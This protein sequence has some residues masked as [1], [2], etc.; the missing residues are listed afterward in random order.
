MA[1]ITKKAQRTISGSL[2]RFYTV[3]NLKAV[4][5]LEDLKVSNLLV[6]ELRLKDNRILIMSDV[7]LDHF[8]RIVS[9]I[10]DAEVFQGLANYS[11][12]HTACKSVLQDLL[13]EGKRPED[14]DELISLIRANLSTRIDDHTFAVPVFGLRLQ[15][16]D[17]VELGALRI[18]PATVEYFNAEGVAH[19]HAKV[20]ETIKGTRAH[21]WL[22]GSF[23][24]T[25]AVARENFHGQ[26]ELALGMLAIS[27]ASMYEGGAE[28]FRFGLAMSA[29]QAHGT[30]GWFSWGAQTRSLTSHF[31]FPHGQLLEFTPEHLQRVKE[32]GVFDRAFLIFQSARRTPLEEAIARAV[33]WFADAQR[34]QVPVMKLVKYWSC[35]ET[36]F[37]ADNKDIARALSAGIA[38]VLVFGHFRF[39]PED[40][41]AKIKKRVTK[42]Y[43]HRSRALHGASHSHV[44]PRD[45]A[46]LSQLIAWMLLNMISFAEQGYTRMEQV[47]EQSERLDR[48]MEADK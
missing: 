8:R 12:V 27:T 11:D 31:Q 14:A 22:V 45:T 9:T 42:L 38:S 25:P 3:K 41:Y 35:A 47:K 19:E 2:D 40:E 15:E 48:L 43:D 20:D 44:S 21:Y 4:H 36:F 28:G 7:A 26:A 46:D 30:A 23:K 39:V 5:S 10:H 33:Y 29:E 1:E 18:I 37:S 24:G 32:S 16:I 6:R 17:V 13:S 34:E